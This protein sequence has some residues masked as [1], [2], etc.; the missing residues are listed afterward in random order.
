MLI[1]LKENIRVSIRQTI[2]RVEE[3]LLVHGSL[4]ALAAMEI[5]TF[6]SSSLLSRVV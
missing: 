1:I 3:I 4:R 2:E 5:L 6:K